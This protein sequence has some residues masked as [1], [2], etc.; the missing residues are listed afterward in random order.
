MHLHFTKKFAVNY[1]TLIKAT[2]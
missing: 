1:A 2:F